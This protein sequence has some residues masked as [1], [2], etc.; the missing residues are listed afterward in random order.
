MSAIYLFICS[1]FRGSSVTCM[2][3]TPLVSVAD[4]THKSHV[5]R[6]NKPSCVTTVVTMV[7]E[8]LQGRCT[9]CC[10]SSAY[11]SSTPMC[12]PVIAD[13]LEYGVRILYNN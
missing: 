5:I 11:R 9:E 10:F 2:N 8:G 3:T 1:A 4:S 7:T 13:V 12:N 6:H